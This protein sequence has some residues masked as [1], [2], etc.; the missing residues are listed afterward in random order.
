MEQFLGEQEAARQ[1]TR[2]KEERQRT[3]DR[4]ARERAEEVQRQ[5][6][7]RQARAKEIQVMEASKI[8]E[9]KRQLA[10]QGRAPQQPLPEYPKIE[11]PERLPVAIPEYTLAESASPQVSYP[12]VDESLAKPTPTPDL[13]PI[14]SV[15]RIGDGYGN[16]GQ[17]EYN[18]PTQPMPYQQAPLDPHPYQQYAPVIHDYHG[19]TEHNMHISEDTPTATA[20]L[21]KESYPDAPKYFTESGAVLREMRIPTDIIQAFLQLASENTRKNLEFCGVLAGSLAQHRFTITHLI[22]PKQSSTSDTVAMEGEEE[23]L[24]VQ[25]KLD[26]LTLGW[27]HTH[28]TQQCFLS[29]VD[30]HTHFP[31]QLMLAEAI[32]I[33]VAPT[34]SPNYG[35]FRLTDPPG[36]DV[37]A[38]CP[39]RG[40]HPHD[41][42]DPIYR[43]LNGI[44]QDSHAQ[45]SADLSLNIIDLR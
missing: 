2:Q 10:N 39:H 36:V 32:A 16:V 38:K 20:V 41:S 1:A 35:V 43:A 9:T 23:V 4:V 30:L 40:F 11:Q 26:L 12:V 31:Y 3:A 5:E 25:D 13:P 18:Y 7:V 27:I 42:P 45:F 34:Q 37:I 29:S 8:Y 19:P 14:A 44:G 17:P 22:I 21:R 15:Y 28:P 6:Q 33:V 24:E